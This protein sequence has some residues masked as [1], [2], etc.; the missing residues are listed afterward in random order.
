MKYISNS[1]IFVGTGYLELGLVDGLFKQDFYLFFIFLVSD[2]YDCIQQKVSD[3][4]ECFQEKVS[5]L[6]ER[7]QEKVSD[8]F[9][10]IQENM[11]DLYERRQ[12][13]LQ[14]CLWTCFGLRFILL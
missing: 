14:D 3:L 2:L 8:L 9:E 6:F 12:K 7:I 1:N 10:R 13:S 4:Y 11:S 5:D